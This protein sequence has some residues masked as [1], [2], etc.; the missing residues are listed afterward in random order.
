MR[1]VWEVLLVLLSVALPYYISASI[2]S[3]TI[4]RD[5]G[6]AVVGLVICIGLVVAWEAKQRNQFQLRSPIVR[7]K[8]TTTQSPES[9][10]R[11]PYLA[12]MPTV[13]DKV[14]DK[15]RRIYT[16]ATQP[17]L[18]ALANTLGL[19]GAERGQLLKPH[20]GKWL[21]V[22]GTVDD[23]NAYSGFVQV[24][25][26]HDGAASPVTIAHFMRDV[27][28]V[29]GLRKGARI[30]AEGKITGIPNLT[31]AVSLDESELL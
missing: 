11:R 25:I 8:G 5:A 10:S 30:R 13:R 27:D 28:R 7:K 29:A 21:R 17:E 19:T 24:L 6:A 1:R 14:P 4:Q 23:V 22:E 20:V 2:P 12:P 15:V 16:T 3:A 31:G 26:R 18:V 9:P